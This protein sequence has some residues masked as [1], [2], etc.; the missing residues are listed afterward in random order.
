MK[1]EYKNILLDTLMWV[2][3]IFM[4][5]SGLRAAYS[6]GYFKGQ[7]DGRDEQRETTKRI[8]C[9][10]EFRNV[11]QYEITGECIKYFKMQEGN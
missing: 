3:V 2:S 6:F 11:P 7:I 1:P 10:V 5:W 4:I 9:E 8:D